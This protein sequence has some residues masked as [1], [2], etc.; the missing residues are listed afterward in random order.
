MIN[1]IPGLHSKHFVVIVIARIRNYSA[2][3]PNIHY[4]RP[5]QILQIPRTFV[6]YSHH[7]QVVRKLKILLGHIQQ[8]LNHP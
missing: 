7:T 6:D 5:L 3:I 1:S 4:A 8:F 2:L